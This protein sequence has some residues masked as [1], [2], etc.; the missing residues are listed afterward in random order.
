MKKVILA[1]V[2]LMLAGSV[3][4]SQPTFARGA[5][6]GSGQAEAKKLEKLADELGLTPDQKS[7]IKAIYMSEMPKIKAIRKDATLT[8]DQK[9][10]Q[11]KPIRQ[12]IR[13]Q[14]EAILTPEQKAKWAEIRKDHKKGEH[15]DA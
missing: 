15:G 7:K 4:T 6:A 9:K 13:A 10:D 14:V 11:I 1:A 5:H 8:E 3:V 2:A 12:G